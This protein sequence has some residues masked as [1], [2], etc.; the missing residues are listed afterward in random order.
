[1]NG[2]SQAHPAPRA[3]QAAEQLVPYMHNTSVNEAWWS[4]QVSGQC[5]SQPTAALHSPSLWGEHVTAIHPQC[6][7]TSPWPWE[8][9]LRPAR[10]HVVQ[11]EQLPSYLESGKK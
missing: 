6:H 5:D 7:S 11:Q 1:M 2:S 9:P 3:L 8:F 10:F 4:P